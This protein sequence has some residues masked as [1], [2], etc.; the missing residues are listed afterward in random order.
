MRTPGME[1]SSRLTVEAARPNVVTALASSPWAPLVAV[2]GHKQVLLY[3]TTRNR[4]AGVFLIGIDPGAFGD[5]S[6]YQR[7][8][9]EVLNGLIAAPAGPGVERVLI[10]GDPE[11]PRSVADTT[12]FKGRDRRFDRH[13][14]VGNPHAS[15]PPPRI[16][17]SLGTI[18]TNTSAAS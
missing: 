16:V 14:H 9:A 18:E 11:R 7:R 12:P 5:A 17:S 3:D 2:A 1:R 10:A 15:I 4:L 6:Q 8:V 13:G